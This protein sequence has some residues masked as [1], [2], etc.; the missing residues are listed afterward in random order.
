MYIDR[1]LIMVWENAKPGV[2]GTKKE[3]RDKLVNFKTDV[4]E[5]IDH[6]MPTVDSTLEKADVQK[7]QATIVTD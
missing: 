2:D 4:M 5:Q 7:S 3:F 1:N 6:N